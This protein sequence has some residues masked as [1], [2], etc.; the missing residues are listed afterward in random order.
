[1]TLDSRTYNKLI[2]WKSK[3]NVS[4]L[5][6]SLNDKKKYFIICTDKP[7][8][9]GG[10]GNNYVYEFQDYLDHTYTWNGWQV[11]VLPCDV[12]LTQDSKKKNDK[13]EYVS[14]ST[15]FDDDDF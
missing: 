5:S 14:A 1:M 10:R 13:E 9:L 3:T 8:I 11:K 15:L 12:I 7:N 6:I 2:E 4:T